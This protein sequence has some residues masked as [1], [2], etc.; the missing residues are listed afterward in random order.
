MDPGRFHPAGNMMAGHGDDMPAISGW[1]W[2]PGGDGA[3]SAK[4]DTAADNVRI[5][6][7][8]DPICIWRHLGAATPDDTPR[9]CGLP[10]MT[11]KVGITR[12]TGKSDATGIR[13]R[14]TGEP[15]AADR[16]RCG[17]D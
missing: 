16:S 14:A 8:A 12:G 3:R 4:C 17:L 1:R 6:A 10:G 15:A 7:G 5:H 9:F 13:E 2:G 11:A